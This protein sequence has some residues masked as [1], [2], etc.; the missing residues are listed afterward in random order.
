MEA[1]KMKI[2]GIVR[3]SLV[4]YPGK[5]AAA[6]FTQG[7]N[8]N[9]IFCHNRCLV[10]QRGNDPYQKE[11]EVL[12]FLQRRR[13]FL[14]GVVVTGGEP[15]LQPDLEGF[16][17]KVK[18]MGFLVKLDTNGTR[19]AVI[20][21]LFEKNLVDYVAMDVKAPMKK[22]REIC[23][24]E[25]DEQALLESMTLLR[26][27]DVDYEFRTTFCPQLD[28]SDIREIGEMI[29]GSKKYVLQ[30]YRETDA[31]KGGYTGK[32]AVQF[33][34]EPNRQMRNYVSSFQVRGEI[35]IHAIPL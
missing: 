26:E 14:D 17:E 20:K 31:I 33:H 27:G 13:K 7:C 18:D 6:V 23:R 25:I 3:Q 35:G 11:E 16:I 9:C 24:S 28:D 4:D 22:Y 19:P 34:D 21:K 32:A 12:S 29:A 10:G 2:A 8:M 5:I 1:L 15:T 30:Q